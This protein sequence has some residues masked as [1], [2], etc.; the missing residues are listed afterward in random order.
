MQAIFREITENECVNERHLLL[1][2]IIDKYCVISEKWCEI[3]VV[4]MGCKT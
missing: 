3:R 1:K 4:E 2:A